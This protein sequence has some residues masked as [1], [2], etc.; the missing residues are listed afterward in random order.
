MSSPFRFTMVVI[1]IY[2]FV[3]DD[4][5]TRFTTRTEQLAKCCAEQLAKCCSE[6]L[7][8]C[9]AEQLAKCREFLQKIRVRLG[10]C[11]IVKALQLFITDRSKAV[12]LFWF[13]HLS[14]KLNKYNEFYCS[15]NVWLSLPVW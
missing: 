10:A 11:I 3:L 12:L 9:C 7:A 2:L 13:M 5:L 6:Q 1:M 8:K 4:S 15:N 14:N